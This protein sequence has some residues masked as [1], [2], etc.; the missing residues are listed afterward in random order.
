MS[1]HSDKPSAGRPNRLRSAQVWLSQNPTKR[2][3]QAYRKHYNVPWLCALI[4]LKMLGYPITN[5]MIDKARDHEAA[6]H[7]RKGTARKPAGDAGEPSDYGHEF[8]YD[9]NFS[10]IAGFTAGGIPYGTTWDEQ[11][12]DERADFE[13]LPGLISDSREWYDPFEDDSV[14]PP[15][16]HYSGG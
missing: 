8:G 7:R 14:D 16:Q 13:V 11:D 5:E 3:V 6:S 9:D 15:P 1:R 10:F 2:I 4:E 12:Y